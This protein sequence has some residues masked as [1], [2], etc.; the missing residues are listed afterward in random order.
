LLDWGL[1]VEEAGVEVV[2][3]PIEAIQLGV[4]VWGGGTVRVTMQS[5]TGEDVIA[6]PPRHKASSAS[7]SSAT[8][9]GRNARDEVADGSIAAVVVSGSHSLVDPADGVWKHAHHARG[10]RI[11]WSKNV[12]AEE[13][14][15]V[16]PPAEREDAFSSAT[17][18]EGMPS[19][20]ETELLVDDGPT[21]Y[22]LV[23]DKHRLF[24]VAP[25]RSDLTRK[26]GTVMRVGEEPGVGSEQTR[27]VVV[28][29]TG[30][31]L[32]T[33]DYEEVDEDDALLSGRLKDLNRQA[34]EAR[35]W[36]RNGEL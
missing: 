34:A 8:D 13:R 17:I 11:W 19:L 28:V 18:G 26:G 3:M 30:F 27:G 12:S 2:A 25:A 1:S 22:N 36:L 6:L 10:A 20:K 16:M 29:R 14:S 4:S 5:R 31:V 15:R 32:E 9:N 7:P 35:E 23:T 33:A 21:L 24:I